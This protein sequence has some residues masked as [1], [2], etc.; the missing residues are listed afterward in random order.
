MI[1]VKEDVVVFLADAAALADL[2]RHR[3]RDD[4]AAGEILGG[5]GIALHEALAF[6]VGEI[7]ALAARTLGDQ[8][9]RAVD[10]GRVE[11][12]ELHVLQREAG[13]QRH[14]VAVA[15][16]G[17]RRG[18]RLI[19]AA[20]AAGGEDDGMAAEAV[21]RAVFHAHGDDAAAGAVF[22]DQVEREIFDVE[23]RVILQALLV[24]RVEHGVAGTVGR[25]A[26]ALH[27]GAFAHILHVAA[28]RALVDRA[29]V[30]A[31]E[32]HAGMLELDHGRG[33]LAH[34]IFDRVLIAEPVRS[35][36]GVEHV[37]GPVVRRVVAQR[38]GDAALRRHG[39]A[40]GREHLGDAGR[41]EAGLGTAHRRTQARTAGT[42][43]D[44]VVAVVDDLVGCGH[45]AAA[46]VRE[47]LRIE[48]IAKTAAAIAKKL[49]SVISTMRRASRS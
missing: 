28:E 33:R 44:G 15:G 3:A 22:H 7:A 35:L 23:V 19:D 1:E 8:H 13:A 12:D 9:A 31:A 6:G 32:R 25:G 49:S 2:H 30:V 16:A 14:A 43:D 34:H 18:R 5:G 37:P 27:R 45:Y 46:P 21:D 11:L 40:A 39:M 29:V 26:G 42:H 20:A 47:I 10:A 48:K 17:V 24:E 4:V 36:D 41:L 38:G